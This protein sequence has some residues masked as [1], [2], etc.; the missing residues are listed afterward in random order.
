ML[1][2]AR[3]E[4]RVEQVQDRVLDPADILADG[5][6]LLGDAAVERLLLGLAGEADEVPGRVR[7]GVERVGLAPRIRAAARA[8]NVLPGRV[9]VERVAGHLER[10]VL[11]QHH[12]QLLARHRHD[13]AN[14]AVDDRDRRAPITLAADAPVAQPV[15]GGALAPALA[16]GAVDHRAL[17]VGD[18]HPVK[19]MRVADHPGTGERLVP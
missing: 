19:E 1:E 7:E 9:P 5:Q 14:A 6:P 16:L 15:D 2:R 13:A 17:G 18:V 3:P 12:R 10:H 8:S 4:T 11:G